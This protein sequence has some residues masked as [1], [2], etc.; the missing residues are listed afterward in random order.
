MLSGPVTLNGPV[1]E[2]FVL[3]NGQGQ[4]AS[5]CLIVRCRA[6][7]FASWTATERFA[8]LHGQV[9]ECLRLVHGQELPV[10]KGWKSR[11]PTWAPQVTFARN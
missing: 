9:P 3:L 10:P 2:G 1:T 6:L 4:N 11:L 8:L 5:F 7:C